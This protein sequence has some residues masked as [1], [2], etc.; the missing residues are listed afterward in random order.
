ML[1]GPIACEVS[2]A[3]LSVAPSAL[4]SFLRH[5]SH[6]CCGHPGPGSS[7]CKRVPNGSRFDSRSLGCSRENLSSSPDGGFGTL[8][9]WH[10]VFV[11]PGREKAV[12]RC[13]ALG[14][15]LGH[16]G[17]VGGMSSSA[18]GDAPDAEPTIFIGTVEPP[19]P[20]ILAIRAWIYT[21][22][23]A[24]QG[25]PASTSLYTP[26]LVRLFISCTSLPWSLTR[27]AKDR[28]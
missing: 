12:G 1:L 21:V 17:G 20:P 8:A 3:E 5:L 24:R 18:I 2:P 11:T 23:S 16:A 19:S 4:R 6:F 25:A 28:I 22:L 27:L 14:G 9:L 26:T 10:P 13:P 7:T 15:T